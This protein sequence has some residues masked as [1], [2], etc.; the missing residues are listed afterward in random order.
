VTKSERFTP[1]ALARAVLLVWLF[2]VGAGLAI[3]APTARTIG[4]FI[5]PAFPAGDAALFE[6][7][8]LY[9]VEAVRLGGRALGLSL[10]GSGFAFLLLA[11]VASFPLAIALAGLLHPD[12]SF[13]SLAGRAAAAMPSLI[14][15]G[16]AVTLLSTIG[17]GIVAA[18]VGGLSGSLDSLMDEPFSDVCV[19]FAALVTLL[20]IVGIGLVHDLARAAVIRHE[21]RAKGALIAALGVVRRLPRRVIF[22]WLWPAVASAGLVALAAA[23]SGAI[24]VSRPGAVRVAGVF[25]IHQAT[26]LGLVVLRLA[27]LG[28]ALRLVGPPPPALVGE[29]RGGG[30]PA[31][32]DMSVLEDQITSRR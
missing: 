16:G 20:P 31:R 6:P 7:G 4:A 5:P 19:W 12:A 25:S 23:L 32:E 24:D 11:V 10:E 3:S 28:A 15:L 2:R 26:V 14:V 18:G 13:A 30:A 29:L 27:W 22:G 17:I 8:G 1:R 21:T 9:L